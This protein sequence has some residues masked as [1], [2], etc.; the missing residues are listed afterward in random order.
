MHTPQQ[1]LIAWFPSIAAR[2]AALE[3]IR[4]GQADS[5]VIVL[6]GEGFVYTNNRPDPATRFFIL[7]TSR[8]PEDTRFFLSNGAFTVGNL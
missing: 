3:K 5:P 1:K 7:F 6:V 4:D 8:G 2:S